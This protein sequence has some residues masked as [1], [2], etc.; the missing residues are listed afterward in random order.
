MDSGLP[1]KFNGITTKWNLPLMNFTRCSRQL[2]L[3]TAPS[4][5]LSIQS[6]RNPLVTQE[7]NCVPHNHGEFE[8]RLIECNTGSCHAK[9]AEFTSFHTVVRL[10]SFMAPLTF[11]IF[12]C[13]CTYI[14]LRDVTD[15]ERL[16][17]QKPPF[18]NTSQDALRSPRR[19]RAWRA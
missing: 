4:G 14:I 3:K 15:V 5:R 11:A 2:G 9:P 17:K 12:F 6:E 10:I 18:L 8:V 19:L 13:L 16:Q 7:I 1:D